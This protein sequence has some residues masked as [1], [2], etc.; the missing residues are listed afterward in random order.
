MTLNTYREREGKKTNR[1]M[2]EDK[3]S[4]LTD[5]EANINQYVKR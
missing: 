3:R 4:Q 2:D 5:G 1:K